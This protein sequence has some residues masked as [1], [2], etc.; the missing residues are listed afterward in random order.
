MAIT[1]YKQATG[2]DRSSVFLKDIYPLT[3]EMIT[4]V[5]MSLRIQ[6]LDEDD[7]NDLKQTVYLKLLP[8]LGDIDIEGIRSLKN[9]LYIAIRRLTLDYLRA[10]LY[11]KNFNK[12]IR[13]EYERE[14]GKESDL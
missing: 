4:G 11:Y 2:S 6:S 7:R 8:A 3:E 12:H 10:N 1:R 14:Y 9:Y 5:F 13:N